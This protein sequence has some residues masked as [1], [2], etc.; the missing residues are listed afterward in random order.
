M[1]C[2]DYDDGCLTV[3]R[4]WAAAAPYA[5]IWAWAIIVYC[6]FVHVMGLRED[7]DSR[8]VVWDNLKN[9]II[10][11]KETS[12]SSTEKT[13][14]Q[15]SLLH[16]RYHCCHISCW[17]M[18]NKLG[19]FCSYNSNCIDRLILKLI[20]LLTERGGLCFDLSWALGIRLCVSL[21]IDMKLIGNQHTL[22]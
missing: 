19:L 22:E 5:D 14:F 3:P 17:W 2:D 21:P 16:Y 12:G 13:M 1:S 9:I 11:G 7:L 10:I 8:G 18:E 4:P 15:T 6:R 20:F